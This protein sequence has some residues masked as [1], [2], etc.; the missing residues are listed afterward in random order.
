VSASLPV[1]LFNKANAYYLIGTTAGRLLVFP[2][3]FNHKTGQLTVFEV[4]A[5]GRCEIT[6]ILMIRKRLLVCFE[7]KSLAIVQQTHL[8]SKLQYS[9]ERL[10][11]LT[12]Q[13]IA[14]IVSFRAFL[15]GCVLRT[16][17]VQVSI[18]SSYNQRRKE[19]FAEQELFAKQH[20]ALQLEDQSVLILNLDT[21]TVRLSLPGAACHSIFGIYYQI[22][23]EQI[24]VLTSRQQVSA[25]SLLTQRLERETSY[26][27]CRTEF[28]F[29]E[30]LRK[31]L[32][33]L[34]DSHSYSKF[35]VRSGAGY[36]SILEYNNR[37]HLHQADLFREAAWLGK[38]GAVA[39]ELVGKD[40][41]YRISDRQ[42]TIDFRRGGV[43]NFLDA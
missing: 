14:P 10:C 29:A 41:C 6:Q 5:M 1:F 33:E 38:G 28:G 31:R 25:W 11:G 16:F 36:H 30:A 7:D 23:L 43:P 8:E 9:K 40:V 37:Y 4:H 13:Y 17:K 27:S 26:A 39:S 2:L 22:S 21:F 24:W 32:A 12:H 19:L 42:R 18:W 3:I 15:A 34:P 20:I 35:K